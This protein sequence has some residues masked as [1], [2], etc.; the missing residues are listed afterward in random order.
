MP[1]KKLPKYRTHHRT[2]CRTHHRTHCHRTRLP[3]HMQT[4][5]YAERL[6]KMHNAKA[7][8]ETN[9]HSGSPHNPLNTSLSFES[10][11]SFAPLFAAPALDP[12]AVEAVLAEPGTTLGN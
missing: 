9:T 4:L 1:E 11:A 7:N 5:L 8:T 2:H 10:S 12:A 6:K 3:L